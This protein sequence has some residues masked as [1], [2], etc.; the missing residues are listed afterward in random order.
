MLFYL[1]SMVQPDAVLQNLGVVLW[2]CSTDHVLNHR[3]PCR[4]IADDDG[5][6]FTDNVQ[7]MMNH[8]CPLLLTSCRRSVKLTSYHLLTKLMTTMAT[9]VNLQNTLE[10]K[11]EEMGKMPPRSLMV[12]VDSSSR[13]LSTLLNTGSLD[14]SALLS[15]T[16][17]EHSAAMAYLLSWSLLLKL[18]QLVSVERRNEYVRYMSRSGLLGRLLDLLFRLMP[19]YDSASLQSSDSKVRFN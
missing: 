10:D 9:Q 5:S 12:I 4:L 17:E 8:C 11:D 6:G 3:L 1:I 16:S 7:T 18:L 19:Q 13:A 2:L 15:L 14:D